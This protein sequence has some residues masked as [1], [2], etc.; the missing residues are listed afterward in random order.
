MIHHLSMRQARAIVV[1][2]PLLDFSDDLFV[3]R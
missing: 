3:G 1:G 2:D